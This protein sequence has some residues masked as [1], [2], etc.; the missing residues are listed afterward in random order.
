MSVI[1]RD[2][3]GIYMVLVFLFSKFLNNFIISVAFK[4]IFIILLVVL[5]ILISLKI[6]KKYIGERMIY[7]GL[8]LLLFSSYFNILYGIVVGLIGVLLL[9]IGGIHRYRR[10]GNKFIFYNWSE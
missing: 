5:C 3:Y 2:K 9:V 1:E 8:I 6:N 10:L 7:I 4:Y